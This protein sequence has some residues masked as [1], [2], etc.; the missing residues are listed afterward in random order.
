MK[1]MKIYNFK[2]TNMYVNLLKSIYYYTIIDYNFQPYYNL[3]YFWYTISAYSKN[4]EY[5]SHINLNCE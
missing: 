3:L 5:I 1:K 4:F 2:S